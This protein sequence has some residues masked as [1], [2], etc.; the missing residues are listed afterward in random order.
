MGAL[1]APS[2]GV[3]PGVRAPRLARPPC[4]RLCPPP[5]PG[6]AL[7]QAQ[8][9]RPLPRGIARG[10]PCSKR[11][12][13][14]GATRQLRGDGG[15]GPLGSAGGGPNRSS[16]GAGSCGPVGCWGGERWGSR[17]HSRPTPLHGWRCVAFHQ[18]SGADKT[19]YKSTL[20]IRYAWKA[21]CSYNTIYTNG[22]FPHVH[23]HPWPCGG[24]CGA[25]D[26]P[27]GGPVRARLSR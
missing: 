23:A 15:G 20:K 14:P 8:F 13:G 17:R 2:P 26:W 4:P 25:C 5:Q 11:G 7:R 22:F 24:L 27:P 12:R 1:W 10:D 19:F 21:W 6:V 9:P 18:M 3:P 16:G